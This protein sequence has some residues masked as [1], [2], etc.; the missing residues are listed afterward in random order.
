MRTSRD[1]ICTLAPPPSS[2]EA[3][4]AFPSTFLNDDDNINNYN[5][6]P[7]VRVNR[8]DSRSLRS[9]DVERVRRDREKEGLKRRRN[10]ENLDAKIQDIGRTPIRSLQDYNI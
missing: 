7:F 1:S 6:I 9:R 4:A 10:N 2:A 5:N 3:L 8:E